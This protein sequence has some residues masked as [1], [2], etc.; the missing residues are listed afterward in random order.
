MI[1]DPL[2]PEH[3]VPGRRRHILPPVLLPLELRP[4]AQHA[5]PLLADSRH[6]EPRADV[7]AHAVVEVGLPADR[8]LVERF[9][10][11]EDVVRRLAVQDQFEPLLERFGRS[12]PSLR[13]VDAGGHVVLLAADPVAHVGVGEY[14]QPFA[15]ELVVVDQAG[16][17]VGQAIPHVPKEGAVVEE[18]AVVGE[19][20]GAQP[21]VERLAHPARC[22]QQFVQLGHAQGVALGSRPFK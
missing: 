15:V 1:V 13:A 12:Q 17:A 7:E 4:V 21:A 14:L 5:G 16:K 11:H 6:A 18:L 10:A 20:L 9:P 8:L 19:E 2:S 22:G 3:P